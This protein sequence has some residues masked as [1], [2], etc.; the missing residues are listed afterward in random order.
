MLTCLL[1]LGSIF[2]NLTLH[3]KRKKTGEKSCDVS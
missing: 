1:A 3:E 2:H